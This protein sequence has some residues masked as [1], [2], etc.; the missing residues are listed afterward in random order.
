[1]TETKPT[2]KVLTERLDA[3]TQEVAAL[4]AENERRLDEIRRLVEVVQ[5]QSK[6]LQTILDIVVGRQP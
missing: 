6:T 4:K 3:L 5:K 2:L 1:M